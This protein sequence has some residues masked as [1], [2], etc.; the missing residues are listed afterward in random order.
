MEHITYLIVG[1]DMSMVLSFFLLIVWNKNNL[2]KANI[3][4]DIW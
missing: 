1:T 2:E 3:K 4:G